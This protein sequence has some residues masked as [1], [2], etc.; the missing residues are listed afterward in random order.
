VDLSA[1]EVRFT[2]K[3]KTIHAFVMGWPTPQVTIKH[4]ATTSQPSPPKVAHVELLGH[5]GRLRWNQDET[6]LTVWMPDQKPCDHAVA[7]K[8][9]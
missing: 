2:T 7:L 1:D 3:G 9:V 5:G 6:G 4:L 8:I